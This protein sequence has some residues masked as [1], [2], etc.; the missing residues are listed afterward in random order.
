MG[1]VRPLRHVGDQPTAE[2]TVTQERDLF[3]ELRP[4]AKVEL[5]AQPKRES[6][7]RKLKAEETGAEHEKGSQRREP[8]PR[9]MQ[10]S[11]DVEQPPEQ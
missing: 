6:G 5:A 8:L 1:A 4:Q 10:L 7:D 3:E 2:V 11:P 9:Q